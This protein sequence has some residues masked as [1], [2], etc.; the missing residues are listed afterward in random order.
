MG[1][2]VSGPIFCSYRTVQSSRPAR[3]SSAFANRFQTLFTAAFPDASGFPPTVHGVRRG[4]M[5]FEDAQFENAHGGTLQDILRLA[6]IQTEAVG[7]VY[8]VVG[9]HL[10]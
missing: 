9:R 6:G 8:L 1:E 3:S 10:P 4:R 5:Q 2:P 7:H